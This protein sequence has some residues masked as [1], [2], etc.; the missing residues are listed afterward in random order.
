MSTGA[1]PLAVQL[2]SGGGPSYWAAMEAGGGAVPTDWGALSGPGISR[3]VMSQGAVRYFDNGGGGGAYFRAALGAA[4]ITA[5]GT[6]FGGG[7]AIGFFDGFV[8]RYRMITAA[9]IFWRVTS[10]D[11]LTT[12]FQQYVGPYNIVG[13]IRIA[14]GVGPRLATFEI[15]PDGVRFD[16]I[17]TL[18]EDWNQI[19]INVSGLGGAEWASTTETIVAP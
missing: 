6:T 9:G 3:E 4:E 15:S 5:F 7:V 19:A 8:Q 17:G 12:F 11:A 1:D 13:R 14:D 16:E 10:E 18:I 2:P